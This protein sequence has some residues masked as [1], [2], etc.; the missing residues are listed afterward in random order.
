ML[1][2][3]IELVIAALVAMGVIRPVVR[4]RLVESLRSSYQECED[5]S[6]EDQED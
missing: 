2:V 5:P 3:V 6:S 1:V 4:Q